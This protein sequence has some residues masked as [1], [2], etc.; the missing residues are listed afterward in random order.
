VTTLDANCVAPRRSSIGEKRFGA[1][2]PSACASACVAVR[3]RRKALPSEADLRLTDPIPADH[4]LLLDG[5]RLLL[6]GATANH[7]AGAGLTH[8]TK[9]QGADDEQHR[10]DRGRS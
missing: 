4:A 9:R 10:G 5:L 6:R 7:R 3:P 1:N 2:T 8:Q